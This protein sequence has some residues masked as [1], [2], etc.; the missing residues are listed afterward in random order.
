MRLGHQ[1]NSVAERIR[2]RRS[3]STALLE[4]GAAR[5]LDILQLVHIAEVP[6]EQGCI[7]ELPEVLARLQ[8]RGVGRQE[9][10]MHM[11]G[12]HHVVARVPARLIEHQHHRL[13]GTGPS[14]LRKGGE[15][16]REEV[17]ADAGRR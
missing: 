16:S 3:W 12:H 14:G 6:V 9:E 17:G 8:L 7:G 13:G 4:H 15:L 5:Q 1:E 11:R 10:Q 2:L